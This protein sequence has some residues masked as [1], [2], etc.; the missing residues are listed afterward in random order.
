MRNKICRIWAIYF[1]SRIIKEL[2]RTHPYLIFELDPFMYRDTLTLEKIKKNLIK[3]QIYYD[4]M[5]ITTVDELAATGDFEFVSE[6][7]KQSVN[8]YKY[9]DSQLFNNTGN[10]SNVHKC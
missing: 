7:G 5:T 2:N 3:V 4:S 8:I 1:L 9:Y 10:N 6:L